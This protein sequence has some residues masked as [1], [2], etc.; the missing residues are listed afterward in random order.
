[1]D[2]AKYNKLLQL[3]KCLS[4]ETRLTII[5]L[6][7]QSGELCV[8]D[9]TDKIQKTSQP[10]VSRHLAVLRKCKILTTSKNMQWVYYS[11]HPD[12]PNEILDILNTS[13]SYLIEDVNAWGRKFNGETKK[14]CLT[15][16]ELELVQVK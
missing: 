6:I 15:G 1:M 13:A 11:L 5:L 12:I 10:K 16:N 2:L 14:D 9:L 7:Y 4:D 3:F 8:C